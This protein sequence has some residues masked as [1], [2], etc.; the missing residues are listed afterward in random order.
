[1]GDFEQDLERLQPN[2]SRR[3]VAFLGGTLGNLDRDQRLAFLRRTR[4]MLGPDDRLLIGTDLV[5][6]TER[7]EAAYNDSAGVTA[8][9]NRNMLRVINTNLGADLDPDRFEHVAFYD[10]Q[11][12]RIEMRLARANPTRHGS[13]AG[14]GRRIR[15][16]RGDTDGDLLQVHHARAGARVCRRGPELLAGT[17]TATACSRSRWPARPS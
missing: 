1:M 16:R 11:E 3:L 13:R 10:E 14:D 8:E 5:K 4:Q 9:F 17:P 7:L 2:G 15:A 6:D 12:Q